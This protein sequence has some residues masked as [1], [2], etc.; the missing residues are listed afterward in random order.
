[1][2]HT[3]R[4]DT[5][6][7][8]DYLPEVRLKSQLRT[9]YFEVQLPLLDF[10]LLLLL[11]LVTGLWRG[12]QGMRRHGDFA[13]PQQ[14]LACGKCYSSYRTNPCCLGSTPLLD[15]PWGVAPADPTKPAC[16]LRP[17]KAPVYFCMGAFPFLTDRSSKGVKD[18]ENLSQCF[19]HPCTHEIIQNSHLFAHK[20]I[21]YIS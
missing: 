17:P 12:S 21:G 16:N 7:T 10:P 2:L 5:V 20:L 1:M 4:D 8:W 18:Y 3:T 15:P 19:I 6:V 9:Y 13:K 14:R 11:L